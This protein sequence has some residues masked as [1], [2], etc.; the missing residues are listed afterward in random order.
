MVKIGS[1]NV[2]TLK[3]KEKLIELESAFKESKLD[4][5]GLAE[6]RRE[7]EHVAT[8]KRGNLLCYK[9]ND[10][11]QAEVGFLV[12]K[13]WAKKLKEFQGINDRIAK[14]KFEISKQKT[15]T[16]FQVYA[17]TSTSQNSVNE[18]FLEIITKNLERT[19]RN[20]KNQIILM[21]DFNSQVGE[22]NKGEEGIMGPYTYGIRNERGARLIDFCSENNLKIANTRF[23]QRRGRRWTWIATNQKYKTLID[24]ILIPSTS[25]L[26]KKFN[27]L[28]FSF[29]SDHR[30]IYCE[31]II[32]GWYFS[33]TK[34][35]IK[36]LKITQDIARSYEEEIINLTTQL[37]SNSHNDDNI[38]VEYE[39]LIKTIKQATQKTGINMTHG[40][41]QNNTK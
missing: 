16:I 27:V 33:S 26:I 22:R 13:D 38:D 20:K 3:G 39:E 7:G 30:L 8:T 29:H 11:G 14:I 5:L 40:E 41:T 9:G 32:S 1:L 35:P 15:L 36:K 17:P 6:V 10:K 31:I 25:N 37:A 4:I 19:K 24:Y 18:D 12:N 21:G 28:N 2:R 23:K 34:N